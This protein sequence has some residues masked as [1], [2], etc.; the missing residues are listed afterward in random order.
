MNM[1]KLTP[2]IKNHPKS[3][4]TIVELLIVIVVIGILSTLSFV[5]Y[6]G[7]VQRSINVQLVSDLNKASD[8]LEDDFVALKSYPGTIEDVNGGNGFELTPGTDIN[9]VVGSQTKLHDWYCI[10]AASTKDGTKEYYLIRDSN[11]LEGTCPE[12]PEL[13]VIETPETPEDP[14]PPADP[15]PTPDP[16]ATPDTPTTPAKPTVTSTSNTTQT[17][18]SLSSPTCDLGTLIYEYTYATSTA[19]SAATTTTNTVITFTTSTQGH[20]YTLSVRAR[21]ENGAI[22]SGWS[23]YGT[24]SYTRP[25]TNTVQIASGSSVPRVPDPSGNS[26]QAKATVTGISGSCASGTVPIARYRTQK[27]QSTWID[28]GDYVNYSNGWIVLYPYDLDDGD[29]M[30]FSFYAKCSNPSSGVVGPYTYS[31]AYGNIRITQNR[32]DPTRGKWNRNCDGHNSDPA[33]GNSWC[34]AGGDYT[35]TAFP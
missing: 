3:G 33:Q 11:A 23:G 15:D 1:L 29:T 4:F 22:V 6:N 26:L 24:N 27:N 20:K 19:T 5:A 13:A 30:E 2:S 25:V 34:D 35:L 17:T 14:N 18:W 10:E 8:Q 28:R 16:P 9:Y 12:A 7:S 21:C 32:A 31:D